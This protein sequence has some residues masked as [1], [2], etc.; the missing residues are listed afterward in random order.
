MNWNL[1]AIETLF[2][3]VVKA[4]A[5]EYGFVVSTSCAEI[6]LGARVE[7]ILVDR[8]LADEQIAS[9]VENVSSAI[10][11]AADT[12]G[13]VL[14]IT[15]TNT[16]VGARMSCLLQAKEKFVNNEKC[17]NIV[18]DKL[19]Y[20]NYVMNELKKRNKYRSRSQLPDPTRPAD[21]WVNRRKPS[22]R[23]F[24]SDIDPEIADLV[25]AFKDQSGMTK[26][27]IVETALLEF[28]H[29][30]LTPET[31]TLVDEFMTRTGMKRRA[32]IET[33]VLEYLLNHER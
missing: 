20:L 31:A 23:Q 13:A 28:M 17:D 4:S 11:D 19:D 15:T 16:Q 7:I 12:L 27:A 18:K 8:N 14:T 1:S 26:R 21:A 29:A 6:D 33:A 22:T 10:K 3:E 25:N 30:D 2:V 9:R 5:A 24:K 32:L